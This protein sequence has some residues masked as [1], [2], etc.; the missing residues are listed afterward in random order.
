MLRGLSRLGSLLLATVAAG[1]ASAHAGHETHTPEGAASTGS[2]LS[3]ALFASGLLLI[4]AGLYLARRD[5]VKR[6]Y[7]MA[8]IGLG[9]AGLAGA[10]VTLLP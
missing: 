2:P 3:M 7:A 5:D 4:G 9:V 10:V 6:T 8:G 1:T